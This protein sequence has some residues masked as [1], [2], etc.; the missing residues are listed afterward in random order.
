MYLRPNNSADIYPVDMVANMMIT[1]TW[2][3]CKAKP[4][5]PFVINCTSG[6]MRRLTWQQIFDYSKP[7]VLKYPSSEVFR[8]PGGSFK[9]TRF[10]HSVAVQLDHNLP[11]FI[12]DTVA[13]LG[14]YKPM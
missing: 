4:V 2:Y 6:S 10:W 5:S 11:A 1:A 12:A 3:M 14:G 9:T 8:Y 7:L 13:R